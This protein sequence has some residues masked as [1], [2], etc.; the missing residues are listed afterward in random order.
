MATEVGIKELLEAGV[1]FGHQTRR[2][3]PRMRRY[4]HGERDSIH[5]IDLLQTEQL[6][7]KAQ[8]FTA[9]I[10]AKGGGILFV[11]TKKQAQDSVEEWAGKC[12][13]PFV[14]KRWL[15]GLL[16]NFNTIKARIKR[17]HELR[18]LQEGGQLGLLPTKERMSME[19]ELAKLEFNLGGVAD[20]QRVPDAIVIVDLKTEEIALR[21]ADRLGIP[22]VSLVDTNCDPTPVD[23]VVPGNDDAIRSCSL[24]VSALGSAIE[25]SAAAWRVTEE[26]RRAEEERKRA[27]EEARR[28][29]EEEEQKK[30]EAEKE[31]AQKAEEAK[32][33]EDARKAAETKAASPAKPE[34]V[35]QAPPTTPTKPAKPAHPQ[36]VDPDAEA[37]AP[38]PPPAPATPAESK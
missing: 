1:H 30:R 27:E 35:K 25:D 5:I 17:L 21:E 4:I 9:E 12:E 36:A 2:W 16:T 33:A 13:M 3:N 37:P 11:G 7:K 32:R 15:G 18:G 6:L 24:V 22:I 28:K 19:A 14:N 31:A 20:M 8:D 29:A 23:Y 26:K 38:T 34:P 10:A